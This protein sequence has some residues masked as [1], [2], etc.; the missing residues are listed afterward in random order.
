MTL[1]AVKKLAVQLPLKQRIKLANALYETFPPMR[2]PSSIAELERRAEEVISGK[3][4]AITWDEFQRDLD[5]MT[6]SIKADRANEAP[7]RG[8][9]IPKSKA[10]RSA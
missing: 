5:E 7:S 8:R 2:A 9:R 4:K 3:V 1:T 6:K 10:R